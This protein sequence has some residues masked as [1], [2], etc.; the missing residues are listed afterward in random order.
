MLRCESNVGQY[1]LL[2]FYREPL[3]FVHATEVAF[4]V[5]ATGGHLQQNT[6]CLTRRP[7]NSALIVHHGGPVLSLSGK[8]RETGNELRHILAYL[9]VACGTEASATGNYFSHLGSEKVARP[10]GV[11]IHG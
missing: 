1:G 3:V 9:L 7:V 4:V 6:V 5:R 8:L 11:G 2:V 10:M